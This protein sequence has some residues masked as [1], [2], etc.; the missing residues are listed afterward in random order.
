MYLES[1]WKW[2][3]IGLVPSKI[4]CWFY[5]YNL[6]YVHECALLKVDPN[7][8][9]VRWIWLYLSSIFINPNQAIKH[10]KCPQ[11]DA[12]HKELKNKIYECIYKMK[13]K[14]KK[15]SVKNLTKFTSSIFFP[16]TL[17]YIN[18]LIYHTCI[19]HDR[20]EKKINSI[21]WNL[22]KKCKKN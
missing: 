18:Y 19:M 12:R 8:Y 15:Q 7:P 21:N 2:I 5:F 16:K 22:E 10:L 1:F 14:M 9:N 11:K 17:R 3:W 13:M 6:I 4:L 20:W